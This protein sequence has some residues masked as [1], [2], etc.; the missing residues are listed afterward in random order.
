MPFGNAEQV[1]RLCKRK[2]LFFLR[3]AAA[4]AREGGMLLAACSL[5]SWG[6]EFEK[7]MWDQ[8][9]RWPYTRAAPCVDSRK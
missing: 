3:A 9:L 8:F 5:M 1:G 6:C 7:Q 4:A 2:G